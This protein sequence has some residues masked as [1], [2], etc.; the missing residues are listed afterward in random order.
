MKFKL[1]LAICT[2]LIITAV[3]QATAQEKTQAQIKAEE[4]YSK[5]VKRLTVTDSIVT[6]KHH[7]LRLGYGA[8]APFY[9]FKQHDPLNSNTIDYYYRGNETMSGVAFAEYSYRVLS[10]LEVGANL[11]YINFSRQ[12]FDRVTDQNIG[13]QALNTIGLAA[14]VRFSYLN[15]P[16]VRLYSGLALG[17]AIGFEQMKIGQKIQNTA[18]VYFNGGVTLFGI[19]VGRRLYGFAELSIGTMGMA[20]FGIGYRFQTK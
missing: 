16:V 20:N 2:T 1:L 15:R 13:H 12:Y 8:V 9:Q 5:T 14:Q 7:G 4:R 11:S 10:W 19:T 6:E 3:T 17:V 18:Q